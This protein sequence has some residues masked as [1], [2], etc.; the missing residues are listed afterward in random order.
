MSRLV[1]VLSSSSVFPQINY[2]KLGFVS[3]WSTYWSDFSRG[4]EPVGDTYRRF[5]NVLAH[6]I[7]KTEFS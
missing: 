4:T 3:H 2:G 6:I 1:W 7:N 5:Y